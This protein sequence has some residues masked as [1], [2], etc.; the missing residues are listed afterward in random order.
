M[1]IGKSKSKNTFFNILGAITIIPTAM[2]LLYTLIGLFWFTYLIAIII[3]I[4]ILAFLLQDVIFP[5]SFQIK[6]DTIKLVNNYQSG[7]YNTNDTFEYKIVSKKAEIGFYNEIIIKT[8]DD[9]YFSFGE[10]AISNVPEL[11]L[12]MQKNGLENTKLEYTNPQAIFFSL[13]LLIYFI[14]LALSYFMKYSFK[15]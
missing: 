8:N 11:I 12:F 2:L 4:C 9:K 3:S 10:I 13:T 14:V 1:I 6:D 15:T 5:K 7:F